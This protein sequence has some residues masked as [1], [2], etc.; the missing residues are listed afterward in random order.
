M[1]RLARLVRADGL[2]ARSQDAALRGRR[3]RPSSTQLLSGRFLLPANRR[4]A[5]SHVRSN[6]ERH[7]EEFDS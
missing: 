2:Y 4:S 7:S 6:A 3:Y 1:P 5:P